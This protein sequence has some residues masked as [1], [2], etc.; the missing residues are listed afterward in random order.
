VIGSP[1][2][3]AGTGVALETSLDVE[4][5]HAMAPKANILL[6]EVPVAPGFDST[7]L[8]QDFAFLLQGI[9]YAASNGASVVSLSYG[10]HETINAQPGTTGFNLPN[11]YTLNQTY[12][13]TAPI[14]NIALT[15]ST[16]D[17]SYPGFPGTSPNVIGV[18]G[19]ALFPTPTNGYG[20]ETAWGGSLFNGAGG[21]GPSAFFTAPTFQSSNKVIIGARYR[22]IPDVSLLADP[23]TGVSVY[24]SV[25]GAGWTAVGGTSLASPLFAGM[26]SITQE[27]R[28]AASKPILTTSQIQGALYALYNSGTNLN[29]FHDIT[30]GINNNNDPSYPVAGYQTTT[31][32]DLAT[33]IGSPKANTLI[34]YLTSL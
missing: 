9:Q 32:Y 1:G 30:V 29:Y 19:T 23:A 10:Y 20:S 28:V 24:D 22:T 8:T 13:S 33:G 2:S 14:T 15:V 17:T 26:L 25:D 16:G 11:L 27:Q 31:G 34:P 3:A 7:V 5:A 4:W 18:G 12:L 6:V 21:G